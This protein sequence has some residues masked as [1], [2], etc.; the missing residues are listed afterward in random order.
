M[1][2][3]RRITIL[4]PLGHNSIA[5]DPYS[6]DEPH[7]FNR[8]SQHLVEV[9]IPINHLKRLEQGP[10][11]GESTMYPTEKTPNLEREFPVL[12]FQSV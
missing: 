7:P 5:N 9:F 11:P 8:R 6:G 12:P 2:E 3:P 4:C 1:F 10:G